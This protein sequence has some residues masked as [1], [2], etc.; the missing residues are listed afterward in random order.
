MW[1]QGE[2]G[3]KEGQTANPSAGRQGLWLSAGSRLAPRGLRLRSHRLAERARL[4][5]INAW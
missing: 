5:P 1:N 3:T 4:V 2:E